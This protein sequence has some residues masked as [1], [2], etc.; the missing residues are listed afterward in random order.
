[1][2]INSR[3]E[4][5][6]AVND[7]TTTTPGVRVFDT[8]TD[9]DLSRD[10]STSVSCHGL[11][12]FPRVRDRTLPWWGSHLGRIAL[13]SWL[14]RQ[15]TGIESHPLSEI[16]CLFFCAVPSLRHFPL[17]RM[18]GRIGHPFLTSL[19]E[20]GRVEQDARGITHKGGADDLSPPCF[21]DRSAASHRQ[22]MALVVVIGRLTVL[23][24]SNDDDSASVPAAPVI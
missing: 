18:S 22:C 2:A 17:R 20:G 4:L 16:L 7:T 5:Y 6:V 12:S 14:H 11:D 19:Q 8:V 24:C 23:G 21:A 3:N 10:H 9:R 13:D 15:D 1:M